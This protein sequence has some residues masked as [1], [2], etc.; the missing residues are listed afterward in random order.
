MFIPF[1]NTSCFLTKDAHYLKCIKIAS[2]RD[3]KE[4]FWTNIFL[5]FHECWTH[6]YSSTVWWWV[7]EVAL[8][9]HVTTKEVTNYLIV[10]LFSDKFNRELIWN[11]VSRS[12]ISTCSSS[13]AGLNNTMGKYWFIH[14]MV[15]DF[16]AIQGNFSHLGKSLPSRV[17]DSNPSNLPLKKLIFLYM[18]KIIST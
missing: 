4:H 13:L 2:W 14:F 18:Y 5:L 16:C 8:L 12:D 1:L 10:R 17:F 15:I 6:W 3:W 11:E 7:C 9:S